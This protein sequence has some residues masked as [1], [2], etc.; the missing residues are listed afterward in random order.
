MTPYT[1]PL[2]PFYNE[3]LNVKSLRIVTYTATEPISLSLAQQHL[4]LDL[5]EDNGSPASHPDDY[6]IQNVYIPAA[7]EYC[8]S[9]SGRCLALQDYE[10]S[11]RNFPMCFERNNPYYGIRLPVGPVRY[12][13][14]ITYTDPDGTVQTVDPTTYYAPFGEDMIFPNPLTG[15]WPSNVIGGPAAVKINFTAG[16]GTIAGSPLNDELPLPAKY[17]NAMLLMLHHFYENRS[18]TEIPS[19]VPTAIEFGVKALL[20]PSAL[21]MGMA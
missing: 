2:M 13:S 1:Y 11:M 21:R 18:G 4:R 10:F 15:G 20:L 17:L 19:Q 6:L 9:L 7:R 12:V 14:G 8:E 5:Y 16:Y 3:A